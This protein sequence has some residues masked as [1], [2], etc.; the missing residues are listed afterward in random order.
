MY[1][2]KLKH[3]LNRFKVVVRLYLWGVYVMRMWAKGLI[4]IL[5]ALI[6]IPALQ[7]ELYTVPAGISV[8]YL[9]FN[10]YPWVARRMH[11][12]KLTYED[13]EDLQGADTE[14]RKRFQ[15][16]FTRIQQ[17]GGSLCVG[18]LILYGFH[19]FNTTKS[20]FEIVGILGG[21]L[22]LYARIFGY[23]GNF[24]IAFLYRLKR[25][26]YD[27]ERGA[28]HKKPDSDKP[29]E[30]KQSNYVLQHCT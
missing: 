15:I 14:L 1:Y 5:L 11:R 18:V 23:I 8:A 6:A 3:V 20:F 29:Q 10:E 30:T 12:R 7:N 25:K 16:V 4:I 22:S 28:D 17:I 27:A 26:Q 24:C 19:V 2:L 9:V 13:L 21:L